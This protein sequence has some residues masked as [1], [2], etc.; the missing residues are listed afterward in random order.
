MTAA[1]PRK[2]GRIAQARLLI[3]RLERSGERVGLL[4]EA[5]MRAVLGETRDLVHLV[6]QAV[7]IERTGLYQ[8]LNLSLRYERKAGTGQELVH[9]QSQLRSGGG[10]RTCDQGLM[11]SPPLS[12]QVARHR[13]G[14]SAGRYTGWL[15]HS[16]TP[17]G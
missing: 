1:E 8:A 13:N 9:V 16:L 5:D 14:A 3:E 17:E 6:R 11:S 12:L 10:I 2:Q 7:R 4:T 15:I